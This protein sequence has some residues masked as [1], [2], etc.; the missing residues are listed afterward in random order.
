MLPLMKWDFCR[1]EKKPIMD[2]LLA[3]LGPIRLEI[4]SDVVVVGSGDQILLGI[5][6]W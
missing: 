4:G 3:F 1:D 2:S 6:A 5:F